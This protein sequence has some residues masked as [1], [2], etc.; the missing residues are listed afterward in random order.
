MNGF[1]VFDQ[2]YA[3][4]M[5]GPGNASMVLVLL[6]YLTAFVGEKS[7]GKAAAMSWILLLTVL[8]LVILQLRALK[9]I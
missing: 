7:M 8:I 6:I 1:Q 4:T 9:Q 3:T 2:V 5:G